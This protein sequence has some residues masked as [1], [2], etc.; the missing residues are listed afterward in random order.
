MFPNVTPMADRRSIAAFLMITSGICGARGNGQTPPS[1]GDSSKA[2]LAY[3][4]RLLGV[5]DQQSGQPVEGAEVLD[6]LGGNKSLTTKTGT[7]S[8]LFLPDGGTLVRVRKVGFAPQTFMVSIS[9]AD[10]APV[11]VILAPVGQELPTVVVKDSSVKYLSPALNGFEARRKMGLG[12]FISEAEMRKN[13]NH[14]MSDVLISHL[15]GLMIA[16]APLGAVFIVTSRKMCRG[17]ALAGC[18]FPNCYPAVLVDGIKANMGMTPK[19]P[20]DWSKILPSDYAAVEYYAGPAE[21]PVEFSGSANE[22][23]LLILWT[24][25]R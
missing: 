14:T 7:V 3:R 9:P 10:T 4:Y 8:L 11:T 20:P 22:C 15:P 23:G 17:G 16:P 24:R 25:E 6:V 2:S 12:H 19:L 21:A 18:K 1:R 13:D 5:Y